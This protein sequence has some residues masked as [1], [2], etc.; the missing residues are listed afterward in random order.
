[1]YGSTSKTTS[2]D[3]SRRLLEDSM[4]VSNE[5]GQIAGNVMGQLYGQREALETSHAR[6]GEMKDM[7][8]TARSTLKDME[9]KVLVEMICLYLT[10]GILVVLI[11]L[12]VYREVTNSGKLF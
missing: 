5:T 10:I 8:D 1:M 4:Q 11:I 2:V 6:L 3:Q 12:V 9:N 7:T